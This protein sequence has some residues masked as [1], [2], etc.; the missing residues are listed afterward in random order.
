MASAKTWTLKNDSVKCNADVRKAIA[1]YLKNGQTRDAAEAYLKLEE[2][3]NF[4]HG[5]GYGPRIAYYEKALALFTSVQVNDRAAATLKILGDFYQIEGNFPK[6]IVALKSSLHLYQSLKKQD[7]LQGL[8]DL[9]GTVSAQLGKYGEAIEYGLLAVRAA[10]A[11]GDTSSLQLSTTLNRMGTTYYTIKQY[12]RALIYFKKSL[13]VAQKNNDVDYVIL[14]A[15]NTANT[16]KILHRPQEGYA[17]MKKMARLYQPKQLA[18]RVLVNTSYL[19]MLVAAKSFGPGRGFC[20]TLIRLSSLVGPDDRNQALLQQT[21][22]LYFMAVKDYKQARIHADNYEAMGKK[23]ANKDALLNAYRTQYQIDSLAGDEVNELKNFKKYTTLKD[24]LFNEKTT[25]QIAQLEI[26]HDM[27]KKKQEIKV[28]ETNI[29]ALQ[30]QTQLQ[31]SNI[32]QQATLQK[33]SV[34]GLIL[35]ALLLGLSYNR[36]LLKQRVNRQ[37]QVQQSEINLKNRSLTNL[38]TEKDGLLEEKEWLMKEIHHRVKN[39]LQIVI[40]LLN[41]QSSYLNDDVAYKAIRESQHRMQSI[42][43]IHQKL[44]QSENMALVSMPAYIS[45]LIQYLSDSFDIAPRIRFE[46]D[47]APVELDVTK[48]VPLGLILNEAITNSIK[49]AFTEDGDGIIYIALRECSENNYELT[50]RD[51]GRGLTENIDLSK[52][53]TLGMS[54]MRGL[55]KQLS[56]TFAVKNDDGIAIIINFTNEKRLIA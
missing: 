14:L 22:A 29:K 1:A 41:T 56:G 17:L 42:S 15:Y 20:D 3:Y 19:N 35:L 44:Y 53:R 26:M 8:Y 23:T 50:I 30:K 33:L 27:E 51:N 10:E 2:Y 16:L 18:N 4:F 55:S 25:K 43:L 9:I 11:A 6:S 37:L 24:V 46:M 13:A 7:D 52:S 36:Y 32:K 40:S 45:D 54:L 31:N 34:G 28:K 49:Y 47:I 48:S 39:N 38:I 5:P 21:I 12:D